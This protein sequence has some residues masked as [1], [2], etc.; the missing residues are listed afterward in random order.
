[1]GICLGK[2]DAVCIRFDSDD[3]HGIVSAGAGVAARHARLGC[4][5]SSVYVL[6]LVL[7]VVAE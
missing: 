3:S 6:R 1:M 7:G 4:L 2:R 5:V